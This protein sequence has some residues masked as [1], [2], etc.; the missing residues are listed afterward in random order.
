MILAFGDSLTAG[1]GATKEESYPSVLEQ[2]AGYTVINAGVSGETSVEGSIRFL[3][4]L[5]EYRPDL[6][7]LCHGGNDLL[8]QIEE[9]Q[10][11]H[12]LKS[13]IEDAQSMGADLILV[14]VPK[15]RFRLKPPPFYEEIAKQYGIPYDGKILGQILS[16]PPLRSDYVHPNAEGY[17][18]LA[19]SMATLIRKS[20]S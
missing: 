7:I 19:E 17:K 20:Q 11:I 12:N 15:P 10:T 5:E 3:S 16:K 6:V 14:G 4:L 1:S 9:E 13:M 18:K 8:Q 2:L